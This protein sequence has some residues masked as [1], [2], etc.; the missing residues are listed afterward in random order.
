MGCRHLHTPFI[1]YQQRKDDKTNTLLPFLLQFPHA[2][3][4][5]ASFMHMSFIRSAT[6]MHDVAHWKMPYFQNT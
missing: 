1:K 5:K 2:T 3:E 6:H 4:E